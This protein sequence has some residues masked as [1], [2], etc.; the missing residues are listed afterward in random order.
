[1]SAS[2]PAPHRRLGGVIVGLGVIAYFGALHLLVVDG[3][4]P[5]ITVAVVLIPW[6]FAL[7]SFAK[8]R[9]SGGVRLIS[10]IAIAA[11]TWLAT[12]WASSY[13]EP[14]VLFESAVFNLVLAAVFASSLVGD[15]DALITR[16]ARIARRGDMP[17]RVVTYTRAITGVWAAFFVLCAATS[18]LLYFKISHEAWS[19]FANLLYWPLVAL[20]FVV[21]YVVRRAVLT[22]IDHGSLMQTVRTVTESNQRGAR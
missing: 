13:P 9:L 15:R 8:R 20:M 11:A 7:A 14:T 16:L 3:R 17:P 2:A 18:S 1:M 19:V 10:L 5:R 22:D 6:A 4:W 12:R 21:E